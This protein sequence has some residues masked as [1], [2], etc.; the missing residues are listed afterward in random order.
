MALLIV[1]SPIG[2]VEMCYFTVFYTL[3]YV[4][5]G[6]HI[7]N[8]RITANFILKV[9]TDEEKS[10]TQ[11]SEPAAA[12][13]P[14]PHAIHEKTEAMKRALNEWVA[15]RRY[16]LNDQTIDDIAAD[17]GFDRFSSHGISPMNCTPLSALGAQNS[18]SKRRKGC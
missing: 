2:D 18:A 11:P 8:Y 12:P 17:L 6:V 5:M 9:M 7:V 14:S 15:H 1:V 4:Y 13:E 16:V 3:Y 10:D